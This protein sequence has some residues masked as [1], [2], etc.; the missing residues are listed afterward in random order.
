MWTIL[1]FIGEYII[2]RNF[3]KLKWVALNI[4]SFQ[5]SF[6][7]QYPHFGLQFKAEKSTEGLF[8]YVYH[9][10]LSNLKKKRSQRLSCNMLKILIY[11]FQRITFLLQQ[12]LFS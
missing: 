2:R 7:P 1:D 12:I 5:I 10:N 4:K 11:V 8:K 6:S 9:K 3:I